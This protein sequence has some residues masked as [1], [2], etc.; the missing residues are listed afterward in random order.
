M[1]FIK[2]QCLFSFRSLCSLQNWKHLLLLV[3]LLP[4]ITLAESLSGRV[5]GITDGDTLTLLVNRTQYKVRLTEIDT[6]E[7]GQPWGSRATQALGEK[8]V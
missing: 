4:G 6:P 3:L 2:V 1:R 5:V 8:V 7:K